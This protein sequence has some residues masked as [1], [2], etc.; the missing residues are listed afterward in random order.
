MFLQ[1]AAAD[2]SPIMK[3]IESVIWP[4]VRGAVVLLTET[5]GEWWHGHLESAPGVVGM[6]PATYVARG[7]GAPREAHSTA[8]VLPAAP[9]P[10]VPTASFPP[11]PPVPVFAPSGSPESVAAD[12]QLAARQA[13]ADRLAVLS[14][15]MPIP[16]PEPEPRPP[17]ISDDAFADPNLPWARLSEQL[18][19]SGKWRTPTQTELDNANHQLEGKC[20]YVAGYGQGKVLKFQKS[21]GWGVRS[22]HSIEFSGTGTGDMSQ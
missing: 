11:P 10:P 4:L 3:L 9:P 2:Y 19:A 20:I 17:A 14:T 22:A 16:E 5:E 18:I 21:G 6:F 1:K 8:A 15:P 13:Q 7:T 12:A